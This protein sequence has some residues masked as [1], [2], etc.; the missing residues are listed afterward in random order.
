MSA[1]ICLKNYMHDELLLKGKHSDVT[2]KVFGSIYHLHKSILSRSPYFDAMFNWMNSSNY[3]KNSSSDIY[4]TD[5]DFTLTDDEDY[6]DSSSSNY[7][8]NVFELSEL[9]DNITKHAF[10]LLLQRLY[11]SEDL[12]QEHKICFEMFELGSFFNLEDVTSA[13]VEYIST[14]LNMEHVV[15]LTKLLY[16]NNYGPEGESLLHSCELY[17]DNYGWEAGFEDW[18]GVPAEVAARIVYRNEFFVPTDFERAMFI[19]GLIHRRISR[20]EEDMIMDC[21]ASITDLEI[22]PLFETLKKVKQF[23]H[24]TDQESEQLDSIIKEDHIL[25]SQFQDEFTEFKNLEPLRFGISVTDV[26]SIKMGGVVCGTDFHYAGSNWKVVAFKESH[27]NLKIEMIRN[28][29]QAHPTL[30]KM[31]YSFAR[32]KSGKT[33]GISSLLNATYMF[34]QL[35]E[36]KSTA[37]TRKYFLNYYLPGCS[38]K[39]ETQCGYLPPCSLT[40][41]PSFNE[42]RSYDYH[43]CSRKVDFPSSIHHGNCHFLFDVN[44]NDS[45]TSSD[46]DLKIIFSLGSTHV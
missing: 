24:F 33:A 39:G 8:S 22:L 6:R 37:S 45:S 41:C 9:P 36:E 7:N 44:I 28:A 35:D 10:S 17:L 27:T 1:L 38:T 23:G 34:D 16:E 5:S 13:A 18:D 2:V 14:I 43:F 12:D 20:E 32:E 30:K 31:G 46:R 26:A 29:T 40:S 19:I 3:C 21:E 25:R 42:C 15:K 11:G 4:D